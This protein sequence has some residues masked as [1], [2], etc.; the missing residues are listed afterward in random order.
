M[1]MPDTNNNNSSGQEQSLEASVRIEN[2]PGNGKDK[3]EEFNKIFSDR[4]KRVNEK[5]EGSTANNEAILNN[6]SAN[7]IN[8]IEKS[9]HL[10]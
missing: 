2:S 10:L 6:L 7:E 8:V 3:V 4:V 5:A 1:S 9:K